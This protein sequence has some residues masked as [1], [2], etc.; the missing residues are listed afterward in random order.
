MGALMQVSAGRRNRLTIAGLAA[1]GTL[2][3]CAQ[4]A[5]AKTYVPTKTGDPNPNGCK[6][7]DCSLRE[8]VIK[9]NAHAGGDTIVLG[10][11]KTYE[12]T[13][14]ITANDATDGDLNINAVDGSALT[15]VSSNGKLAT[16]DANQIDGVFGVIAGK[17]VFNRLKIKGGRRA[18]GPG[19]GIRGEQTAA[20]KVINS[21]VTGN[22]GAYA[23]AILANSGPL[24]VSKSTISGNKAS[25]YAGAIFA[26][27]NV[28]VSRSRISGNQ[29]LNAGA[30]AGAIFTN[31]PLSISRSTFSG[32]RAAQSAGAI[33][34]NGPLGVSK[35][36]FAG[37][38]ALGGAGG[39]L[40]ANDAATIK[41]S[42]ISSNHAGNGGG[43]G[44]FR[45]GAFSTATLINDTFAKNTATGDGGGIFSD[46]ILTMN[47]VTVANN[48]SDSDGDTAGRGGGGYF[49][50]ALSMSNSL[51]AKNSRGQ[52][53]GP[54][55]FTNNPVTSN[56]H[57]LIGNSA[58]CT[59]WIGG[60]GYQNLT[61]AKIGIASLANNG[62]PTKTIALKS[63]SKAINHAGS[64]APG[65]DQRGVKR[66]N[67]DIGS[68]ER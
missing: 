17:T 35:S 5:A 27:A 13:R 26:N 16:I 40:F 47:A 44:L 12:L 45:S 52:S 33:W 38:S 63:G 9:A 61:S 37:N 57:N 20:M 42:T 54:D 59:D 15:I 31:S 56:G 10:G 30:L 2:L 34:A 36:T 23:G 7:H 25:S 28:S 14:A 29:A 65:R 58:G 43:G 51:I 4:G 3:L 39:A 66:H 68:F 41:Q 24:H 22:F 32:N 53:T 64:D 67:P 62:G 1:A 48:R 50:G 18:G 8:A 6:A 49:D 21:R 46:S 55:C 60:I 11:G 19:G